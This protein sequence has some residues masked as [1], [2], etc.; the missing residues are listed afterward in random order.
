MVKNYFRTTKKASVALDSDLTDHG[1]DSLDTIELVIQV[2]DE[3]GYL[4]DAE[5]LE[6]F[7]KPKHFVNFI[8]HCLL[9]TSPSPRDRQKSR[10]PS[11][12]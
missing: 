9:Y 2:E 6:L 4:I 12:A 10:M 1:L 3:L 5:K 11:S 8:S 7:K